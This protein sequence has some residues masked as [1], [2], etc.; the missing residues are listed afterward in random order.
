[1][2]RRTWVE[3]NLDKIKYN[4]EVIR[5][6]ANGAKICCVI[7]DNAYGHG[8][9]RLAKLYEEMKADYFAVS[10][11]K[12]ARELRENGIKTPIIILGFT[13]LDSAK[14]LHDLDITQA[15]YSLEYAKE[16]NDRG[17]KLKTHLKID[18]GMN[19]IGFKDPGEMLEAIKLENLDFEGVF[20]HFAL[21]DSLEHT[22]NQY[23]FFIKRIEE[24]KE[25]GIEFKIRHCANSM[26]LFKHPQ[27]NLDMV[28][29]G[30]VLYGLGGIE[31]LKPVLEMKSIIIQ[32]KDV[33]KG[34]AIG[35]NRRFIA[36]KDIKVATI[37]VGYGDGYLRYHSG[38]NTI[39]VNGRECPILGNICMDQLMIDVSDVKCRV[40]D[41]VTVYGDLE[42]IAAN[43]DTISYELICSINARVPVEYI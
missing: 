7:K 25:K 22:L 21:S 16:L 5:K 17:Y 26:C 9:V 4:F 18:S 34:E 23:N 41:E 40:S 13:P 43:I 19:R 11:I 38:K 24:L 2:I 12:E 30:I 28:R 27:F 29:P 39:N 33:K 31:E 14:E 3:I 42:K 1:M 37:P 35:Y 32:I 6:Q 20:T 10:N 36:D 8:A 15:I